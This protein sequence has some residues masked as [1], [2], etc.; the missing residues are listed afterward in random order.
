[1][2]MA[3][4]RAET[5]PASFLARKKRPILMKCAVPRQRFL[6]SSMNLQ[7]ACYGSQA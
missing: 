7:A 2:R 5:L 4:G 1:M 3:C 6:R